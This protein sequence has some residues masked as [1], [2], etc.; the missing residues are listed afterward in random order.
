VNL[1]AE[2]KMAPMER[3]H[4]K[5]TIA[6]GL[7]LALSPAAP[8]CSTSG[9]AADAASGTGGSGGVSADAG[10][11]AAVDSGPTGTQFACG[12]ASC[13]IGGTYCLE[14]NAFG[15]ASG[16]GGP[17]TLRSYSCAPLGN[18]GPRDCTCVSNSS[19]GPTDCPTCVQLDAGGILLVC[20]QI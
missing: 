19:C 3:R 13:V 9:A 8:A 6:F 12:D 11:D 5:L 18:C 4:L 16:T 20:Q 17:S 15:G 2:T 10:R 1:Q 14:L 7:L